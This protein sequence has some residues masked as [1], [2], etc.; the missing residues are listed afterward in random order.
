MFS[1]VCFDLNN[2]R[3]KSTTDIGLQRRTATHRCEFSPQILEAS[4]CEHRPEMNRISA[5]WN[6]PEAR[7]S[8]G[9]RPSAQFLLTI[10]L[11]LKIEAPIDQ[12][13]DAPPFAKIGA[14]NPL[15][16]LQDHDFKGI[17]QRPSL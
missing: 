10:S 3:E 11:S 13:R 15:V 2:Y 4:R 14:V 8:R 9:P 6:C 12:L 17:T 7:T 1:S 16:P 5:S